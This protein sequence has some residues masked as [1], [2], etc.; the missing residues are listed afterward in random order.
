MIRFANAVGY[1]GFSEMQRIYRERLVARSATYRERI[2]QLRKTGGDQGHVLPQL[3][4]S[5]M[6]VERMLAF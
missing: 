2:E 5:S 3:V 1:S 4:D 6:R